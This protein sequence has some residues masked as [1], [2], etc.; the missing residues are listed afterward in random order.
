MGCNP[1][2]TDRVA[3]TWR[4]IPGSDG[5]GR[6]G[7]S[8]Q[9]WRPLQNAWRRRPTIADGK[10]RGERDL[11]CGTFTRGSP[12][13]FRGNRRANF[14]CPVGA[15]QFGFASFGI[16]SCRPSPQRGEGETFVW[17]AVRLSRSALSSKPTSGGARPRATAAPSWCK[18]SAER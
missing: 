7:L 1:T 8:Q 2:M 9:L 10:Q 18:V 4:K 17:F 6:K 12:E 5:T 13:S 15:S 3:R 14:R 16:T 11:F